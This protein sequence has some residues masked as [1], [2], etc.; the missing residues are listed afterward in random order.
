M[1]LIICGYDVNDNL[2]FEE[3]FNGHSFYE[4]IF[5]NASDKLGLT[6]MGIEYRKNTKEALELRRNRKL[7]NEEKMNCYNSPKLNSDIKAI[8]DIALVDEKS[9]IGDDIKSILSKMSGLSLGNLEDINSFLEEKDLKSIN[10]LTFKKN[11]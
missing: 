10:K 11:K 6:K 8:L 2:I 9:F 3:E 1:K 7:T 4:T 5:C